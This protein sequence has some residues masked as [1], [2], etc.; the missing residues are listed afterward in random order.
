ML[1]KYTTPQ[2]AGFIAA[3]LALLLVAGGVIVFLFTRSSPAPQPLAAADTATRDAARASED[4]A[5]PSDAACITDLDNPN[6]KTAVPGGTGA[7]VPAPTAQA[8]A[9]PDALNDALTAGGYSAETPDACGARQLI[10]VE[11]MGSA[12]TVR[13]YERTHDG[14]QEDESLAC[15]GYVGVNG[16]TPDMHEGGGAAPQGL[17]AVGSAFYQYDAPQTGLPAFAI[18]D[19][20]YWIDDPDRE[21]YNTLHIGEDGSGHGEA[22][23]DIPYYRYGFVIQYNMPATGYARGS[24]IFFHISH[25]SPTQGCVTVDEDMVLAYLAKLDASM[26]PYILIL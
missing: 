14:W 24:A 21:D 2:L 6:G 26:R 12:A 7:A 9:I 13:F 11:S 18:T 15:D 3:I 19:D 10:V 8:A 5:A 20:A 4:E 1:K 25:D 23:A 17:F 22:M 16:T